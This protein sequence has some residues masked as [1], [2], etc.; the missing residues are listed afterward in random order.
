MKVCIAPD[1]VLIK[2]N[3]VPEFVKAFRKTMQDFYQGQP[4]KSEGYARIVSER[5]WDRLEAVLSNKKSGKVIIGGQNNKSDLFFAP[6]VITDVDNHDE[7]LMGD[8]IFGP[9]LPV[10]SVDNIDQAIDIVN[11]R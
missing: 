3:Q 11:S 10:I 7:S 1:Y 9:I 6:T 8:E 4:E 2:R 5:H